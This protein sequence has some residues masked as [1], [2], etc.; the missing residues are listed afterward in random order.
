MLTRV[1]NML[2]VRLLHVEIRR[3]NA[4]LKTLLDQVVAER[5]RSERLA[6]QVT[7][8]SIAGRCRPAPMSWRRPRPT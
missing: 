2:E 1:H 3:K 8:D 7:P 4:E 6:L 5:Q